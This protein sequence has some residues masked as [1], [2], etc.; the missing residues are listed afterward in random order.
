[1][2]GSHGFV[3]QGGHGSAPPQTSYTPAHPGPG[4]Q[5][6]STSAPFSPQGQQFSPSH[7]VQR[8]WD[9]P[10][11]FPTVPSLYT[12]PHNPYMSTN[13]SPHSWSSGPPPVPPRMGPPPVPERHGVDDGKQPELSPISAPQVSNKAGVIF[14][15]GTYPTPELFNFPL[16]KHC[17]LHSPEY[18]FTAKS[19]QHQLDQLGSNSILYL[20]RGSRWEVEATITMHTFQ[21]LATEGYPAAEHEM[22]W[23]EATEE[24]HGHLISGFS[25][26]G[27]RIRNILVEGNREKY[28]HDPQGGCMIMLGNVNT[29]NQVSSVTHG[30]MGDQLAA[31][32]LKL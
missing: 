32:C 7:A 5:H 8:P 23:L 19:I 21:E 6:P 11:A 17:V 20:P 29:C 13:G 18:G 24:C 27:I 1:M 31:P 12:Q 15:P 30:T 3:Q 10:P 2:T 14:A 16:G 4:F 28:G 9:C 25:K 22:A 26:S